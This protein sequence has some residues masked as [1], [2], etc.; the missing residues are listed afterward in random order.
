LPKVKK[1]REFI[2]LIDRKLKNENTQLFQVGYFFVFL[3]F[4]QNLYKDIQ[5]FNRFLAVF[6]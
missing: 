4:F 6:F 5:F 3:I 2:F 1:I